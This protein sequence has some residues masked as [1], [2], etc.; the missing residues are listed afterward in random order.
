[1]D[2][3]SG[4]KVEGQD[5]EAPEGAGGLLV[6]GVGV[7][8]GDA[9]EHRRHAERQGDL[10]GGGVLGLHEVHVLRRQAHGL[11]VE[12]AFEQQRTAGV[13]GA[14]ETLLE[15]GLEAVELLGAQVAFARGVDEGAGGTRRVVEQRLVPPGRRVV[16]V[17][18]RGGGLDGG[19]AVVVVDR[20]EELDVQDRAHARHHLAG[21]AHAAAGGRVLERLGPA[22]G[23]GDHLHA[24]GAQR[25][26][27][28]DLA[29]KR[30]RLEVGVAGDEQEAVPGLEQIGGGGDRVGAGEEVEEGVLGELGVA[31]VEEQRNAGGGLGQHAHRAV[32]D[33][34]LGEALAGEGGVVARRP[35]RSAQRLEGEQGPDAAGL[36]VGST[37]IS[38][39]APPTPNSSLQGER[40]SAQGERE[41][42]ERA[43]QPAGEGAVRL[44]HA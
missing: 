11:P 2:V 12:A 9:Q 22:V 42:G 14:L 8:A 1:M 4:R 35:D 3:P 6:V 7:V 26:Q 16:D 13:G 24:V 15:L 39:G 20:V 40:E 33:G 44:G 36:G 29:G 31:L 21:E 32:D 28:A 41:A 38:G 23:A 10:A 18:R 34:I 30:H 27:L 25:V 5:G 37:P 17:D 43:G 19:E